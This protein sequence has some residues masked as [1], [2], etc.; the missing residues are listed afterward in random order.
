MSEM[1]SKI[2]ISLHVILVRF[3]CNLNFVDR[4]SKKIPKYKI[5]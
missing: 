5:S 1:L 3:K 2:C 4:F